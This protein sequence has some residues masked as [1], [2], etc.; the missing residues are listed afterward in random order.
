MHTEV[1]N[2]FKSLHLPQPPLLTLNGFT[3][4][5]KKGTWRR[6]RNSADKAN[7][8]LSAAHLMPPRVLQETCIFCPRQLCLSWSLTKQPAPLSNHIPTTALFSMTP[9]PDSSFVTRPRAIWSHLAFASIFPRVR[10]YGTHCLI[11]KRNFRVLVTISSM[12]KRNTD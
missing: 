12:I 7:W 1:P 6:L 2:H 4:R 5:L 10:T 3:V 8:Y 11:F 9:S